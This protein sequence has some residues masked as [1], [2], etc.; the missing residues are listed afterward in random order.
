MSFDK[1]A[2]FSKPS[3]CREPIKSELVL[4][5]KPKTKLKKSVE[6][7]PYSAR[8]TP[9]SL[10]RPATTSSPSPPTWSQSTDREERTEGP[11]VSYNIN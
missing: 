2:K 5:L 8:G 10:A 6:L 4:S 9:R 3:Q 1:R 7:L 11:A